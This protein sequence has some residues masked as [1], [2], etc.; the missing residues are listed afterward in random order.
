MLS[1]LS[2]IFGAARF[3][4]VSSLEAKRGAVITESRVEA[5]QRVVFSS[6]T[7]SL[8]ACF[9]VTVAMSVRVFS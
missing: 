5:P 3:M 1:R 6:F 8:K 2:R 7:D 9:T 4:A